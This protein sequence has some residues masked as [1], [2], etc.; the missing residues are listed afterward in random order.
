ML[1]QM[2]CQKIKELKFYKAQ[3]KLN[4]NLFLQ[5]SK[6]KLR[7]LKLKKLKRNLLMNL[8]KRQKLHK[9]KRKK[10]MLLIWLKMRK[11]Y[12]K[13]KRLK[14]KLKQITLSRQ[15][16]RLLFNT[17]KKYIST[18]KVR[19]LEISQIVTTERSSWKQQTSFRASV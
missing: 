5:H 4:F 13:R 1:S 2:L 8:Q 12:R 14:L 9:K 16:K 10:C 18:C 19:I 7:P 15:R 11:D 3:M 6:L 17:V